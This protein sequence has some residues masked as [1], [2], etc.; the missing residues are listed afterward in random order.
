MFCECLRLTSH[1]LKEYDDDDDVQLQCTVTVGSLQTCGC[2][3]SPLNFL[4]ECHKRRQS[5]GRFSSLV[6]LCRIFLGFFSGVLF[7]L[8]FQLF[9]FLAL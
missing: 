5:R 3:V 6:L 9:N 8:L 7:C 1:A 4:A 2:R